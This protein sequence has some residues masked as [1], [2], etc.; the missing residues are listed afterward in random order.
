MDTSDP[1]ISALIIAGQAFWFTFPAMVTGP[2]AV[3][4]GGGR[5]ID[6]GRTDAKGRRL[7]GDGKTWSGLGWGIL[8]GVAVGSAMV[9]IRANLDPEV[10]ARLTDFTPF[11]PSA[12]SFVGPLLAMCLGAMVGDILFSYLK[13]RV[14]LRRGARAPLVDQLDFL[15][16]SWF[17]LL[18]FYPDWTLRTFTSWHAVAI[19]IIIPLLHVV[20]NLI[21]YKIGRK[22]EPW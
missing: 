9:L 13:R 4:F 15:V 2:F 20:T 11:E 12:L 16:M 7:L 21:A 3:L 18:A 1:M 19:L 6:G 22:K 17:F 10:Q 14:G 5:P 8:G